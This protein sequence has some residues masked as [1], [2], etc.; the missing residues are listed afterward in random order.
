MVAFELINISLRYPIF[1]ASDQSMRSRIKT[2]VT[3][4]LIK[5]GGRHVE[6]LALD[7][8]TLQAKEG[9]KIGLLGHNGAGKTTLLKVLAG[10]YRPQTGSVRR[11]GKTISLINPSMGLN[12]TLTGYENIENLLLLFGLSWSE[13]R[14]HLP[15]V[16]IF[17]GLGDFLSLP[18][19]SYSAGM[20]ARLAFS[21]ATLFRPEILII[22]EHLGAGDADF[23]E[24][25]KDRMRSMMERSS[26][27][28]LASHTL[29]MI[30]QI[31]N[32]AVLLQHGKMIDDGKPEKVIATYQESVQAP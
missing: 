3:G 1:Q 20:R 23:L 7:D 26:I 16:E 13:I 14:A 12:P 2:V 19:N 29:P 28:I 27:L 8:I 17:S 18:V 10:I 5:K 11:I 32:R 30:R 15:D 31:C 25:A 24:R 9:D 21:V 4:G 6:I 22:D